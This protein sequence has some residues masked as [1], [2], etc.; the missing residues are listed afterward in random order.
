MQL[1]SLLSVSSIPAALMQMGFM[2]A[3][4]VLMTSITAGFQA[5]FISWSES[6][7]QKFAGYRDTGEKLVDLDGNAI[8]GKT[9][10]SD[11]ILLDLLNNNILRWMFLALIIASVLILLFVTI[12]KI[13][14]TEMVFD[15]KNGNS[16]AQI[17][18]DAFKALA[19]F[20][21]VPVICFLGIF[22]A[23]LLLGAIYKLLAQ[24]RAMTEYIGTDVTDIDTAYKSQIDNINKTV[25]SF[26]DGKNVPIFDALQSTAWEISWRFSTT[27]AG[28]GI[29][30]SPLILPFMATLLYAPAL[31]V[32]FGAVTGVIMRIYEIIILFLI[33]PPFV[34]IM[35]LDSGA[36]FKK[37]KDKFI[38]SVLGMYGIVISFMLVTM[39]MQI[40]LQN[41]VFSS[42]AET[43][44]SDSFLG[45]AILRYV[46]VMSALFSLK[47]VSKMVS[48]FVGGEDIVDKGSALTDHLGGAAKKTGGFMRGTAT[49]GVLMAGGAMKARGVARKQTISQLKSSGMD[50]NEAKNA[51]K[52]MFR[53]ETSSKEAAQG[54]ASRGD[55]AR[56]KI[57]Q[58]LNSGENAQARKL[59][60]ER[61]RGA[62]EASERGMYNA[63]EELFKAEVEFEAINNNPNSSN[64]DKL[65][66]KTNVVN[67]GAA[68]NTAKARADKA[69]KDFDKNQE[70]EDKITETIAINKAVTKKTGVKVFIEAANELIF[71]KALGKDSWKSFTSIEKGAKEKGEAA[72]EKARNETTL[73]A[74]KALKDLREN[75]EKIVV[76]A[77]KTTQDVDIKGTIET[78]VKTSF[79]SVVT[80]KEQ[81]A[82]AGRK[83]A[84]SAAAEA[85]KQAA[86]IEKR[87]KELQ[88]KSDNNKN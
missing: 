23:N 3:L 37:W 88:D 58:A 4:M 29:I 12:I 25:A 61:S 11:D 62:A 24:G 34:G 55:V 39:L 16:K 13:I 77:G 82:S 33:A 64:D 57:K 47:N 6:F 44:D 20:I 42:I 86:E 73:A 35:P 36:A 48:G 32:I 17:Y 19:M 63:R 43:S 68:Y 40:L 79:K 85:K 65:V 38:G 14:R 2:V 31:K 70:V 74:E 41:Q 7:F 5:I 87:L 30:L 52:Y 59:G 81:A 51:T 18:K 76:D 15:E 84:E 49:R 10:V 56:G 72:V 50:S 22:L 60:L 83:Q 71:D 67:K 27:L 53:R 28:V 75:S 26:V 21:A 1:I 8:T 45:R 9:S 78:A 80:N 46:I 54:K 66:A 69:K